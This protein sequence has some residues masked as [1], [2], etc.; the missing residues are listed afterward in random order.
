MWPAATSASLIADVGLLAVKP[1]GAGPF[2]RLYCAD[3]DPT[4]SGLRIRLGVATSDHRS[5]RFT[6]VRSRCAFETVKPGNR[7]VSLDVCWET[8]KGVSSAL[9]PTRARSGS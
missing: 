7:S 4:V 1:I 8:G 9:L 2:G 3:L 5:S 6:P